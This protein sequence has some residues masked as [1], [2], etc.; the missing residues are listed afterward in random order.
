VP[1]KSSASSPI[2]VIYDGQ[3]RLCRASIAWLERKLVFKAIAF[4]SEELA[5]FSLTQEECAKEVIVIASSETLRGANAVS[6]LLFERGNR[7]SA[8]VITATGSVGRSVYKWVATHRNSFPIKVL[9]LVL[10]RSNRS[11][12]KT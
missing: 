3:C 8:R 1:H 5:K 9:T 4:Q 6:Y 10:E 2:T 11:K 12:N 7:F